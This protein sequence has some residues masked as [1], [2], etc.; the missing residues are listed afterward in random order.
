MDL[1]L[2]KVFIFCLSFIA[3]E[4]VQAY[5]NFIG[6][7]YHNCLTCHYNPFGNGP[8]NDYGRGVAASALAG[9][10][11][12]S[13][14]TSDEAL[15][16]HSGFL[17]NKAKKGSMF[18]PAFDYRGMTLRR[19]LETDE[20]QESWINMQM[21]ANLTVEFGQ[22]Q[23][24]IAT[25]TYSIVPSNSLPAG[26]IEYGVK[27]GE[28]LVFSREHYVGYK[29]NPNLGVYLGKMDKVFGIRV[30]DHTAYSRLLTGNSQYGSTHGV[31]VHYGKE[32]FDLGGQFFIG[33]LE[34]E[35]DYRSSGIASKFEYSFTD[36]IRLGVSFLNEAFE[37]TKNTAYSAIAK[38]GIGKGSSLMFEMGRVAT[39]PEAGD[40]V[41]QQYMFLQ[42]HY[43]IFRGFYFLTTYEQRVPDTAGTTEIH[44][45][46]PGFQYFPLQRLELRGDLTN[47]KEYSTGSAAKDTWEF[48][49]QIHLWF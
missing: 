39:T 9:R 19:G 32:K 42:N 12:I 15:S 35:S 6:K 4:S 37:E 47:S 41:T 34:K 23:K 21:D 17:F 40:P 11:F 7:G 14:S 49:G 33:D 48:L 8:L 43:Y 1:M 5:P 27:A 38:M 3:I 16:N 31:V 25:Y 46:S 26:K 10:V 45:F 18:K 36:K 24:Y 28:D 30:P 44:R 13:D 22:N 2:F 20:T 29:F